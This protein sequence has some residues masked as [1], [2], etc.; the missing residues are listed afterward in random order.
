M[1][2]EEAAQ[3]A[4]LQIHPDD[5]V[6]DCFYYLMAKEGK[7]PKDEGQKAFSRLR[8]M[9]SDPCYQGAFV[10]ARMMIANLDRYGVTC[11]DWCK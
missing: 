7:L 9:E 11:I 5:L 10:V 8:G 4:D 2:K 1:T 6:E 3:I